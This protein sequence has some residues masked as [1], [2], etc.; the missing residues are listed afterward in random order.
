MR[1]P[2]RRRF[3]SRRPVA[4]A[5][6][7][8]AGLAWSGPLRGQAGAPADPS[9]PTTQALKSL[10]VE[11]L[12]DVEVT[13]VSKSPEKLSEAAS[14]IQVVTSADI[15]QS[16]AT[17][18]PEAL[19]LASNLE[20]AQID[21]RQWAITARG[22]NNVFADKMLVLI[23]GRTVYTPLYAGVYWDVQDTMLEDLD[24]IEVI[25]GP[26]A[27]QWG[28][29]AVNGVINITTKSAE[30]TQGG[31]FVAEAGSS[32]LYSGEARY[33]GELAP[34]VYY[35]IYGKYSDRGDSDLPNGDQSANDAWHMGQGGFRLDWDAAQGNHVTVQGDTYDGAVTTGGLSD[36]RMNGANLLTRWSHPLAENSDFQLQIYYDR[37]FR[38][39]PD[40]FGE[41]L[42]TYDVDFEYRLPVG[43]ANDLSLG[44]GYRLQQDNITN[45]PSQ[46]F[47]PPHI[48]LN[49]FNLFG[50]DKIALIPDRLHLTVGTK[51][52]HVYFAGWELEPSGRLAWTPDNLQTIWTAVSRAVRTPSRIDTDLYSPATPPYRLAGG[53]DVSSEELVAYELGYRI[54]VT[55]QLAF[56]LAS[57]YNDYNDLRGLQPLDPP[58]AY[59]VQISSGLEGYSTGAELTAD[60]RLTGWWRLHAGYTEMRVHS[61]PQPG[62]LDR[63]SSR[64]IASDPNHQA[65]LRSLWNLTAD[66]DVDATARY[67]APIAYQDVPGYTE[68]DLRL[69]WRFARGWEVSLNGQNLLQKDHAEF[70]LPNSRRDIPRSVYGKTSWHY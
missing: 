34:G 5:L 30:D 42:D 49:S 61:Q 11:Q 13:S 37:T 3:R 44:T 45:T 4:F 62:S 23:D 39:I 59:P 50:Q 52:E 7:V 64:S 68:L 6:L 43:R 27:T 21:S 14:A 10:T 36:V 1:H 53:P 25:S 67:V 51:L 18:L 60:W 2:R 28:A 65:S 29:N 24:R 58:A 63:S 41:T 16:A 46:A 38:Q 15:Q 33:G 19:R 56:S 54:Q 26:G 17:S 12:M 32:L 55:P 31:L 47:L 66:W 70:N 9:A 8:W 20:V 57:Y 40:S 35:R 69:A 22:F 48:G